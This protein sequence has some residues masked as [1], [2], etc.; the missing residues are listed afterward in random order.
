LTTSE[1]RALVFGITGQ[2]GAYL[3]ALLVAKGYEVHGVRRATNGENNQNL[4]ALGVESAVQWH[5]TDY[6][7]STA[8][9]A[10]LATVAPQ[11]IYNLAAQ[12]S[13]AR[14]FE[15][16]L[17]TAEI[18]GMFVVRLLQAV[19]ETLPQARV[20][21]ASSSEI[22]GAQAGAKLSETTP[23]APVNP[24]GAAK[25]FAHNMAGVYRQS[26]GVHA[27][28]GILFNHESPLRG[29]HFV[30]AKVARAA[31]RIKL[32]LQDSLE[33]GDMSVRRDWGF[34]GDY[35]EA[36]WLMLQ[37]ET[38]GD[39]VVATGE[40]HSLEEFVERAFAVVDLEWRDWVKQDA[41]LLRPVESAAPEAD[42]TKMET[43]LG[44]RA[45]VR[46]DELIRLLVEDEL[47]AAKF[48][49]S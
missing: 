47:Q 25:A 24:Y 43:V 37:Q 30:T 18:N 45:R 46:F 31:A 27:S 29:K 32:G 39:Y 40:L 2:D 11:E 14:S 44:W 26:F 49:K 48:E 13:V 28:C 21:Q 35:V 16:P 41:A 3:A 15:K 5:E 38:P 6:A 12:S 1:R 17:E 36:M 34:A 42:I 10:L 23:L 7:D 19:R 33:L 22:F 9:G 4:K 8:L 20:F